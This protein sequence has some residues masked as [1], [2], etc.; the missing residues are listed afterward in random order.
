[1]VDERNIISTDGDI[2]LDAAGAMLGGQR[3]GA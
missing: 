3:Q 2:D 1:M